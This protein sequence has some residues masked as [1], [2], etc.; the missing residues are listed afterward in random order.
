MPGELSQRLI[1]S[2][3]DLTLSQWQV[4]HEQRLVRATAL[5]SLLRCLR[6]SPSMGASIPASSGRPSSRSSSAA[7]PCAAYLSKKMVCRSAMSYRDFPGHGYRRSFG[8]LSAGGCLRAVDGRTRPAPAG[9]GCAHV[10]Q[11]AV[12]LGEQ[13]YVW[14]LA[15]HRLIADSCSLALVYRY[16][17]EAYAAAAAGKMETLRPLPSFEAYAAMIARRLT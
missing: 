1:W 12:R 8:R 5:Y 11:H 15:L 13:H 3:S 16:A 14:R 17:A 9:A 7:M 4:W 10:C 6:P 2:R